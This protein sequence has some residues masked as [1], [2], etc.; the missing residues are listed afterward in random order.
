[1]T[2]S[3]SASVVQVGYAYN[4]DGQSCASDAGAADGTAQGKTQRA[5]RITFRLHDT[6]GLKIGPDFDNLT[7]LPFRTSGDATNA[8]VPLFTGD[9]AMKWEGDYSTE[10]TP[11][12][13]FDGMAPE[14]CWRSCR[15]CTLRIGSRIWA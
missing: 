13:R 6:L 3:R 15:N 4:S 9:K 7:P 1:V 5:H 10:N 8:A 14:R 12:W 11:C 2:L